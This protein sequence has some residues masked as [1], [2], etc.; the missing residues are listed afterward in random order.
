M[1][2]QKVDKHE[3]N[4]NTSASLFLDCPNWPQQRRRTNTIYPD[5]T[6]KYEENKNTST[7]LFT[8]MP[9]MAA[10]KEEQK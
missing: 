3:E 6:Q 5:G 10:E 1:S 8:H 9:Q 2:S 7:L 4:K